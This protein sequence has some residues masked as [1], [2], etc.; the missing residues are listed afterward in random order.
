MGKWRHMA[1]KSLLN[2]GVNTNL[3]LKLNIK[4]K[5]FKI[6]AFPLRSLSFITAL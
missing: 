2:Q 1:N 6:S 4:D 3:Q 5:I